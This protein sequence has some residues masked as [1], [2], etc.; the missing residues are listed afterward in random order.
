MEIIEQH[1]II[2]RYSVAKASHFLVKQ[3]LFHSSSNISQSHSVLPTNPSILTF[4]VWEFETNEISSINIDE[5]KPT[6]VKTVIRQCCRCFYDRLLINW[7]VCV[8]VCVC[9]KRCVFLGICAAYVILKLSSNVLF[10]TNFMYNVLNRMT[11]GKLIIIWS[12]CTVR[13]KCLVAAV[14]RNCS[15][16]TRGTHVWTTCSV[17]I[18]I[19][20]TLLMDL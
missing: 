17:L 8:C 6:N 16:N 14:Y 4:L 5:A 10:C 1:W 2:S 13:G 9:T 20:E 19:V 12:H 18:S 11:N 15:K 7:C 3:Q